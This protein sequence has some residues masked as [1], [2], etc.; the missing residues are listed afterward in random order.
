MESAGGAYEGVLSVYFGDSPT[1][2]IGLTNKFLG[3]YDNS[4]SIE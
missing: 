3:A 4:S 2:I 1:N